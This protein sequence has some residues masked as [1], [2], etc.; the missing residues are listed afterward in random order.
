M[1]LIKT[2]A[3]K[4]IEKRMLVKKT[5]NQMNKQIEKLEEQKQVYIDAAKRATRE[6]LSAQVN[7]ALSGLKMTMSQQK[8]AKEMLLNFEITSQMKDMS[9]MTTEFLKAMGSLSKEMV[10]LTDNK[11]FMEVQKEFE[12]AMDGVQMQTEQ[13]DVFLDMNQGTFASASKDSSGVTDAEVKSMIDEELSQ[14]TIGDASIDQ[15]I[16]QIKKKLMESN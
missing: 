9:M 13:M 11:Q 6:G 12:K 7:L 4:E 15:E 8:K 16:E 5:L 3:E 2:K 1:G 10:K 14:E